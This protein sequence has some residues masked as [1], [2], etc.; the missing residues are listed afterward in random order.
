MVESLKTLRKMKKTSKEKFNITTESDTSGE[1]D[2]GLSEAKTYNVNEDRDVREARA[3]IDSTF[4]VGLNREE[5]KGKD[6]EDV[7]EWKL[8][9]DEIV[10]QSKIDKSSRTSSLRNSTSSL[11]NSTTIVCSSSCLL[12]W[13]P[14]C[15][16]LYI[17]LFL[18]FF[19]H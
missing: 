15:S 5:V 12:T 13:L 3:S 8:F 7:A 9:I 18:H 17:L 11:L 16:F 6:G 14:F 2:T 19:L 4:G 10:M 1:S